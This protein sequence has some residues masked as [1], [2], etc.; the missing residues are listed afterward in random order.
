MM[1]A[2]LH[3]MSKHVDHA[4]LG[5][6]TLHAGEELAASWTVVIEIERL[7]DLRLCGVQEGAEL[8][9]VYTELA[10]VVL[11]LARNPSGTSVPF[12][13]EANTLARGRRFAGRLAGH[14]RD[15]EAFKT[16]FAG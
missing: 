1:G 8:R 13:N 16:L 10:V 11:G 14:C 2:V 5:D 12:P 7:G 15:D 3:A 4:A 9:K 6:L